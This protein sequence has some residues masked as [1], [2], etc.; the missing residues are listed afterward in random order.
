MIFLYS[1][2]VVALTAAGFLIRRRATQ[3]EARYAR[4]AREADQL[5]RQPAYKEGNSSKQDP[6]LTAKKQY[7]LALIAD[8]RD[9]VEARYAAAQELS[10]KFARFARRVRAWKGRTL[11][12][13]FGAVDVAMLLTLVDYF[14]FGEVVSARALL[15]LIVSRFGG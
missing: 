9:K 4:V 7:A 3:L 13:T 14:G 1:L 11:P 8:K 6:Y 12:Y 2:F 5:L 15:Q 10:E